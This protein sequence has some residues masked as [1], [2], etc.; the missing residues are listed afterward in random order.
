MGESERRNLGRQ[1]MQY[2]SVLE[3]YC[4]PLDELNNPSFATSDEDASNPIQF[5]SSYDSTP[6]PSWSDGDANAGSSGGCGTATAAG[7]QYITAA[8]QSSTWSQGGK[9]A[10]IGGNTL[11]S[12]M[13]QLNNLLQ[14]GQNAP[15]PQW[16]R[17]GM[18]DG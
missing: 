18:H 7:G 12:K 2:R 3:R 4:I 8:A 15:P 17:N 16:G 9:N 5:T 11:S 6:L 1:I 14:D 10:A 13:R